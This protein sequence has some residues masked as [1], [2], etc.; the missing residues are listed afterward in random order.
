MYKCLLFQMAKNE[1]TETMKGSKQTHINYSLTPLVSNL[2][3]IMKD[4]VGMAPQKVCKQGRD[5]SIKVK[6]SV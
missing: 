5:E 4:D 1:A 3:V 6:V 2:Y